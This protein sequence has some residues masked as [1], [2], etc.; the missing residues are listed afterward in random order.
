MFTEHKE[1]SFLVVSA[2]LED[3]EEKIDRIG[4]KQI[5]REKRKSSGQIIG[6]RK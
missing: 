1:M 3:R 5:K 4:R 2:H 6:R